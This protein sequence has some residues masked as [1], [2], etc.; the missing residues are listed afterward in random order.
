MPLSKKRNR[1]RQPLDQQHFDE[2]FKPAVLQQRLQL[3]RKTYD[4]SLDETSHVSVVFSRSTLHTWE[5]GISIPAID[6]LLVFAVKFGVSLDWLSGA[7]DVPYTSQFIDFAEDKYFA[8]GQQGDKRIEDRYLQYFD[9]MSPAKF[10][11]A[12][13]ERYCSRQ[14]RI[15]FPLAKCMTIGQYYQI[16][17]RN[18]D[19]R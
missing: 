3:L 15:E 12:A 9:L 13:L 16:C 4:M 14:T 7:S 2:I 10:D 8:F 6:G 18:K 1:S 17:N 11:K 19:I 5:T